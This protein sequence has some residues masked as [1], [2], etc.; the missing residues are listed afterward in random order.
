MFLSSLLFALCCSALFGSVLHFALLCCDLIFDPY[1]RT[2]GIWQ[3]SGLASWIGGH[4][5]PLAEVPPAAAV[6]LI[7]GFLACFTEFASNTATIIIFLPII[8]DLVRLIFN[9]NIY[10]GLDVGVCSPLMKW[11]NLRFRI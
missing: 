7:T 5:Q 11:P 2:C 9:L 1:P 8:A 6:I 3:E 4:L 10:S